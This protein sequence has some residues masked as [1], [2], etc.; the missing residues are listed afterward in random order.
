MER[1]LLKNLYIYETL[2]Q[3]TIFQFTKKRENNW[4]VVL[5]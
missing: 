2:K 4:K 1:D 3:K 5:I